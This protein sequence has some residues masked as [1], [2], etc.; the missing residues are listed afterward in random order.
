MLQNLDLILAVVI[1]SLFAKLPLMFFLDDEIVV[2]KVLLERF[3]FLQLL[4]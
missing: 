1:K 3:L 4:R 2:K